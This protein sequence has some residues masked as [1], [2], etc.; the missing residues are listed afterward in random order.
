M[1]PAAPPSARPLLGLDLAVVPG[2]LLL[3][4]RDLLLHDPPR[5]LAWRLLHEE[6]LHLPLLSAL[7]AR[8]PG[9]VDRDPLALLLAT[10]A[11]ILAFTYLL[12][13]LA[14]WSEARRRALIVAAGL[15]LV[16]V[17]TLAMVDMGWQTGRPYGQDGGVVQLPLAIDRILA[18]RSPYGGDYSDSMLG[19]ESRASEFWQRWGGNPILRHHAYLPG[20]HLLFL[21][22]LLAAR[23][24]LGVFDPRLVTLLAYALAAWLAGGA[25]PRA[26]W[27]LTALALVA[28]N[29]LA[30]WH[31]IFGAN[32][33]VLVALLLGAVRLG[34]GRPRLAAALVGLACAS[35]QL[36]WPFAPFLL[37]G[38]AQVR[39][40]LPTGAS[41]RVGR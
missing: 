7:V 18:G 9:A 12:A 33:I 23:A 29:P 8:M 1:R 2:L 11:S 32:D 6:R 31:L 21:P 41:A 24:V 10:A 27:R 36:A 4:A 13:G 15:L 26:E 20:T 5:V 25:L 14:D 3:I 38:I 37:L 40:P 39:W 22:F 28:I 19:K 34:T 35:K 16:V 17:P 30:Y